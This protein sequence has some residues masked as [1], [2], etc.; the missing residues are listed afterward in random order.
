MSPAVDAS[1]QVGA[2]G[3]GPASASQDI[4]LLDGLPWLRKLSLAD[5]ASMLEDHLWRRLELAAHEK[6]P[7]AI[8]VCCPIQYSPDP[9]F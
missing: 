6:P 5:I 8:R 7:E 3:D 9:P 4:D 2:L 1:Q